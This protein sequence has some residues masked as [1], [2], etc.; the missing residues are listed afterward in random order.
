MTIR[1]A[2][3]LSCTDCGR[4]FYDTGETEHEVIQM[5]RDD[6]WQPQQEVPNGSKW[7][8]CPRCISKRG[9]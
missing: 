8:F 6:G 9:S 2:Y 1:I 3:S 5:A 4:V 7:D